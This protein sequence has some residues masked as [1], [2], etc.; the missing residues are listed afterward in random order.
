MISVESA[1]I[2]NSLT[3]YVASVLTTKTDSIF[4]MSSLLTLLK[5]AEEDTGHKFL[6]LTSYLCTVYSVSQHIDCTIPLS[7]E[8]RPQGGQHACVQ[9][10]VLPLHTNNIA[11]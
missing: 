5:M 1:Q 9:L 10:Q 6:P 7:Q 11:T 2:I 3:F 4:V 8:E